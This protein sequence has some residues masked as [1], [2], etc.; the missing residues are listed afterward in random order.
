MILDTT[1]LVDLQPEIRRGQP[2]PATRV[3]QASGDGPLLI[4]FVTWMAFAEGFADD[5]RSA[6]ESFLAAFRVL[7]PD[8]DT[9]W[10]ASRLSRAFQESGTSIADHDLWI[11]A[12]APE[13]GHAIVSRNERYLGRVPGLSLRS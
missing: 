6:G 3:L 10:R 8:A 11:A 7:W 5:E 12:L 9:A 13:R 1:V 2:G 4:G